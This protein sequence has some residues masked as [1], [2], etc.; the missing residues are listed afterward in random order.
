MIGKKAFIVLLSILNIILLSTIF[1]RGKTCIETNKAIANEK[2]KD[3]TSSRG[4][5]I[6]LV[7]L[8]N[9]GIKINIEATLIDA[10]G[11]RLSLKN[12]IKKY[13]N[14]VVFV[15]YS[16]LDC[17]TCVNTIISVIKTLPERKRNKIILLSDNLDFTDFIAKEKNRQ[18]PLKSYSFYTSETN[19]LNFL[20]IPIE[21]KGVPFCFT[22]NSN[23]ET[24]KIF[25]PEITLPSEIKLYFNEIIK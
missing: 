9:E 25:F 4:Y 14:D 11:N 3:R 10:F 12:L 16:A 21:G 20:D 1:L 2:V 6:L 18:I 5:D 17:N 19:K 24:D 7:T 22:I 23:Y 8:E 15:R 13:G